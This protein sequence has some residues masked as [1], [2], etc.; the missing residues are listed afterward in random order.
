[1][2]QN[3]DLD[4][5]ALKAKLNNLS[6]TGGADRSE[7]I[8]KPTEGRSVIRIVPYNKVPGNPFVELYF[9]YLG[10]KTNI[11]PLSFGRRDPIAEF[12]DRLVDEARPLGREAEKA[13]WNQAKPFRPQ[14]RT[15]VPIIVRGEEAKGVR[16]FAFGQTVFK[17][18][19]GYINDPEWGNI[20]HPVTGRD[21][22]VDYTIAEK[23]DK[24]INGKNVPITDLKVKPNQTPLT[25][26]SALTQKFLTEQPDLLAMYKEL[27]YDELRMVLEKYLNPDGSSPTPKGS[28]EVKSA[29]VEALSIPTETS[30]SAVV[31][32]V[33]EDFDK[34]FDN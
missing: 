7:N 23:S 33:L 32:S 2:A 19:L 20:A 10:G 27:S 29:T 30:K 4:F 25:N 17:D 12:A 1:M 6:K 28:P 24:K 3:Y 21:I 5:N 15:Y 14:L 22:T 26:D 13:A 16:W 31:E 8:W 34:L 11:S 18:L 9:H